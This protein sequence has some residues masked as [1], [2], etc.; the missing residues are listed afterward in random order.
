RLPE[1]HDGTLRPFVPR[2]FPW[3]G[4]YRVFL[5]LLGVVWLGGIVG[6]VMVN[7]HKPEA[8]QP[9]LAGPQPSLAERLRPFVEAAAG[10]KLSVEGKAELERLLIAYWRE[11]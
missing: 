6:F 10:G 7:R 3:I 2:P 11:R 4:G 8:I 1:D 5:G 9:I